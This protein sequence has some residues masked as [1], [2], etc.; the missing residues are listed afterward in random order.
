MRLL[1]SISKYDYYKSLF[2]C[3]SSGS[4]K[5]KCNCRSKLDKSGDSPAF[6]LNPNVQEKLGFL[7]A[8]LVPCYFTIVKSFLK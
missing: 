3:L 1:S 5:K 2:G 8:V 4:D 7:L 6:K